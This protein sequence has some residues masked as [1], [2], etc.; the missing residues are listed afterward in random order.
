MAS[1]EDAALKILQEQVASLTAKLQ[2]QS[3]ELAEYKDAM[4]ELT[5]ERD[6]LKQQLGNPDKLRQE[7]AALKQRIRDRTHLDKFSELAKGEKAKEAAIKHLWK[8]A[9]YNAEAD[10]PDEAALK[11]ILKKLKTEAEYAF[12]STE[13]AN[14]NKPPAFTPPTPPGSGRSSRND[15]GDGTVLTPD[16][17]AN[18]AFMLDPRNK[19]FISAAVK[20]RQAERA[21]GPYVRS[22]A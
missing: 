19:E 10:E 3:V 20:Q 8:L 7:L 22:G 6:E 18:P 11:G 14:P 16:M 12:D 1:S 9:D 15:G 13:P 17:L 21:N 5:R 2:E 4:P